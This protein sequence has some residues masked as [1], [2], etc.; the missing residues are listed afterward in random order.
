MAEI[1]RDDFKAGTLNQNRWP[2]LLRAYGER[3]PETPVSGGCRR[4]RSTTGST[5]L[6]RK[7]GIVVLDSS[8]VA[9]GQDYSRWNDVLLTLR[10][11]Y[12]ARSSRSDPNDALFGDARWCADS[13]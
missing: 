1:L 4:I 7:K 5:S 13:R 8:G 9:V 12:G 10:G 2:E 6:T 11:E 3:Q